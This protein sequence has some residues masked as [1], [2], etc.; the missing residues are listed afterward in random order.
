[1]K[2]S[3]R[4][5]NWSPTGGRVGTDAGFGGFP[6]PHRRGHRAIP[7][8]TEAGENCPNPS[9]IGSFPFTANATLFLKYSK[10]RP[11]F[12][13]RLPLRKTNWAP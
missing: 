1:M 6:H 9:S 12:T 10:Q 11:C 8:A 7:G 13:L 3:S 5:I 4:S 2:V